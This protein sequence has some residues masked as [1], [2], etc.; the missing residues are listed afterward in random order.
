M[1]KARGDCL[2]PLFFNVF[3]RVTRNVK[4]VNALRGLTFLSAS[5]AVK[6]LIFWL[7][8]LKITPTNKYKKKHLRDEWS[9]KIRPTFLWIFFAYH[10]EKKHL[11]RV[12][13]KRVK[14]SIHHHPDMYQMFN[15]ILWAWFDWK[16]LG[17]LKLWFIVMLC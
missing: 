3:V 2:K 6:T 10:R 11:D 7:P 1:R 13:T 9:L 8:S 16:V 5:I 17:G 14:I 15:H 12:A 4:T